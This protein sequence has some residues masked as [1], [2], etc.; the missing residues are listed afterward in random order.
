MLMLL[1]SGTR[2]RYLDD[3][4]RCLALPSEM[5]LQF[6]YSLSWLSDDVKRKIKDGS[7]RGAKALICYIDQS[8]KGA[9]YIIPCREAEIIE[10]K[11][12]GSPL[13][14]QLRMKNFAN[15]SSL[16]QIQKEISASND[17]PHW[18]SSGQL[19]GSWFFE[20]EAPSLLGSS[21]RL[22]SWEA[23][24][25]ELLT[26]NDFLKRDFFFNICSFSK[27]WD[28]NKVLPK[29]GTYWLDPSQE[30]DLEACHFHS[31]NEPA[32][33]K[34]ITFAASSDNLKLFSLA[35]V[36]IDSRYDLK[37]WKFKLEGENSKVP[38]VL[39]I[40]TSSTGD[41]KDDVVQIDL[42]A[43]IKV[44]WKR[45]SIRFVTIAG[46]FLLPSI[47]TLV[48]VD[49]FNWKTCAAAILGALLASVG[50]IWKTK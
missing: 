7:I 36:P 32:S 47:V 30:Y 33:A 35:K 27:S 4:V 23:V 5:D 8:S 9:I 49:K 26:R 11:P 43:I 15:I 28:G 20:C 38:L 18:D 13:A 14:I 25:K 29:D 40:R 46:G 34:S 42:P 6:R 37:T 2:P 39:E 16:A 12:I 44:D 10:V 31:N 22:E 21:S 1:S 41:D 3:I 19:K 50:I 48:T 24:V 45:I 17:C